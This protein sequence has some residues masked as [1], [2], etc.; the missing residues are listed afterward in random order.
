[1]ERIPTMTWTLKLVQQM[2]NSFGAFADVTV[3]Q[4]TVSM[5]GCLKRLIYR[6][7]NKLHNNLKTLFVILG[8]FGV[9]TNSKSCDFV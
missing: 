5:F 1:M 3:T 7:S 8:Y 9:Q 2:A 4:K 6:K